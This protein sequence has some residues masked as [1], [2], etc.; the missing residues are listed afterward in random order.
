MHLF[1][2][3]GYDAVTAADVAQRAGMN[4]RSFFRYFPD[5][6]DVL[7]AG[8]DDLGR[9]VARAVRDD[10]DVRAE[11]APE[12]V[13]AALAEA[14]SAILADPV[15][16]RRRRA[17]IA[18]SSD[19]RERERAKLATTADVIAD[20]LVAAGVARGRLLAAIAVELFHEAFLEAVDD[21]GGTSF[22]ER[23][24]RMRA[25]AGHVLGVGSVPAGD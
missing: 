9:H 19:L 6:R 10:P 18:S 17:V 7:F 22:A 25:D 13:F 2:E 16:Q 12:R 1:E 11:T 3:L 23:L 14:G 20:A 5:K 8:S 21:G 4:R 15:L 24:V